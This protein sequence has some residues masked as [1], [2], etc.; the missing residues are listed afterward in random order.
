M[1]LDDTTSAVDNDTEKKI[2]ESIKLQS[3]GHTTFI[4]SHRVSSF[5][6]ADVIFVIQNGKITQSGS[7]EELVKQQ[8][9]YRQVWNEQN[10]IREDD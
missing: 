5:E 10:D 6:N 3:Q 4:I 2:R 8:G 9:Y 1:I 7:H